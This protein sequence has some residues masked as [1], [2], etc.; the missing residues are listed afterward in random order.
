MFPD[1]L[2]VQSSQTLKS[3]GTKSSAGIAF[4]SPTDKKKKKKDR[5]PHFYI[6]E[7]FPLGFEMSDVSLNLQSLC[8]DLQL[9]TQL[10]Q[11]IIILL[12]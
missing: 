10:L 4:L 9:I 8:S 2:P 11:Y 6:T 5:T 12:Q 7:L 1:E 3:W